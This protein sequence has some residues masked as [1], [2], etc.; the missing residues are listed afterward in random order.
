MQKDQLRAEK[1]FKIH[2]QFYES[3]YIN[4][5]TVNTHETQYL[6]MQKDS[7]RAEKLFKTHLQFYFTVQ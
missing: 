7:L 3:C 6:T 2:L 4:I 5:L 1:L